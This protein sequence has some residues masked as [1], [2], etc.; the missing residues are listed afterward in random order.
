M[1]RKPADPSPNQLR[2]G[3]LPFVARVVVLVFFISFACYWFISCTPANK[4]TWS[5]S[6]PTAPAPTAQSE[7]DTIKSLTNS[8][9]NSPVLAKFSHGN[10]YHSQLSCLVCHR[11]DTNATKISLPGKDGHTPC[12]GCH[13]QQ[14]TD[15]NSPICTVCHTNVST[16]AVK[17]FPPLRSFGVKFEHS[18]HTR[19]TNCA[20]CHKPS[21]GGIA[22]SIPSAA[23]AHATCFQCHS[24]Q[25]SHNM[26]S[27]NVCHQPGG[28]PGAPSESSSAFTVFSHG[29]HNM[30]CT[31]C[32]TVKAGAS[33]GSQVSAPRLSMHLTP[34]NTLACSTCHN[35][36]RAFGGDDFVDCKRCHKG[37]QFQF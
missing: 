36:K 28:R 7:T 37:N 30:A 16:G 12:I 25:A 34:K 1:N 21:Q 22:K 5:N 8:L 27:C 35:N 17:G 29:K 20:T 9:Q 18:Q 4:R 33:R 14:F 2:K 13:T 3:L 11:R 15:N 24:S 26:S 10:Q 6:G 32:H 23:N 19:L 31:T